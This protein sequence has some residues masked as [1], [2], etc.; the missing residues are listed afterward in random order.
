MRRKDY[1]KGLILLLVIAMIITV[2]DWGCHAQEKQAQEKSPSGIHSITSK[3]ELGKAFVEVAKK[4]KPS[5]V[6]IRV[7][8]TVTVSPW[9]WFGEDFFKGAPFAFEDFFRS[10]PEPPARRRQIGGGSGVIVD[11]KGYILTNHHVVA[12][13]DRI[14]IHLFDGKELKGTVQGTDPKTDLAVV[15]L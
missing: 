11:P 3:K 1:G 13:A 5:V 4:V 7:E 2:L 9:R 12:G 14:I 6:S 10:R 15:K 8:R